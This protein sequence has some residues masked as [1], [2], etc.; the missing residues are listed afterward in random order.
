LGPVVPRFVASSVTAILSERPGLQRVALADGSRAFVLTGLIGPVATGDD[1]VVNTTAVDLGLGTGGWHVVH[2]NL[3]GDGWSEPGRGHIM[4]LR[5][6]SLQADV[7]A[8]EEAAG[9]TADLSWPDL[10]GRPVVVAS[11]HSQL[12][13][14]AAVLKESAPEAR[15]AYVMTDGGAL[16]LALSDLVAAL[17]DRGLLDVT[18]TAGQAFGGDLE[19]VNAVSA[20]DVAA[21]LGGADVVVVA[22]GPGV[23]GT[24]SPLGTSALEA[25]PV[26][27]AV[28]VLG[29]R[30]LLAARASSADRRDRHRG[31]SHHTRTILRLAARG[32]A[33][34]VAEGTELGEGDVPPPHRVVV[35]PV[36]EV[37]ALLERAG[38]EVRTMGRGPGDDPLFFVTTAAAGV[39]AARFHHERGTL[40]P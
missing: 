13:I 29:G 24:G 36:P 28:P 3:S 8:A 38:V 14:L 11:V 5:Y 6:T 20:L 15:L 18:V 10:D 40:R 33:V 30:S 7:G 17:R 32:T 1:V 22:M 2:W 34:P 26:L 37:G 23:V 27:D 31:L 12:G 9:G 25:A 4:K 21:R 16:P 19:A 39:M 35:A